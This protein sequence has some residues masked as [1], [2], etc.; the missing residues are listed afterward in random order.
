MRD[1]M[2][3]MLYTHFYGST[4]C[5]HSMIVNDRVFIDIADE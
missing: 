1:C 4:A 2:I 3:R 5:N